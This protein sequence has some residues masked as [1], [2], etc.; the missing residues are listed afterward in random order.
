[1]SKTFNITSAAIS[2]E[3]ERQQRTRAYIVAMSVRVV[4]VIL[5]F[6]VPGWWAAIPALG[7]I[8]LPAL[9]VMIAN[10]ASPTS[11]SKMGKIPDIALET[12]GA[13]P[14]AQAQIIVVDSFVNR[15]AEGKRI[16]DEDAL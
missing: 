6:F 9:A 7:A 10:V 14:A 16:K 15:H 13:A 4:C 12:H 1:M 3:A 11:D 2:P 5:I 8:F